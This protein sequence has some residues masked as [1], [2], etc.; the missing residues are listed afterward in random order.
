MKLDIFVPLLVL[1]Y[2]LRGR[3]NSGLTPLYLN[4]NTQKMN[5]HILGKNLN[6]FPQK[7]NIFLQ[8]LMIILEI[9]ITLNS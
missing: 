3:N 8:I 5:R 9:C 6:V 4:K 2:L 1:F 7:S